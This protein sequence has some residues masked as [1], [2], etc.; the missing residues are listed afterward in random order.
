MSISKLTVTGKD[1]YLP[2]TPPQYDLFHNPKYK[3]RF[4][5]VP[6][7]RRFGITSSGAAFVIENLLMGKYVLWVDTIQGNIDKY[8]YKYFMPILKQI[9]LEYWRYKIASK[10]LRIINGNCDFR[11]LEQEQRIEGFGYHLIIV[12]EAGIVLKGSKG[13]NL[14]FNTLYPMILDYGMMSKVYFLGTPKGKKARKEE[15]KEFPDV[16]YSLYYE[17]ACKGGM[18]N[19][20][21]IEKH[22]NYRTKKYTSYDN[23]LLR[24]EDIDELK[25]DVPRYARKQEIEAEFLDINDEAI[26]KRSWFK[27]VH[28]LP[29]VHL[30]LRKI[31]SLDTAFKIG[32]ANDDSAGV[33][34]LETTL[35][36]FF[37][38]CFSKKLEFPDLIKKS[39]EFYDKNNASI[40]VIEDK[41]SGTPLAQSFKSNVNNHDLKYSISV[42][43]VIPV[44]D[45]FN[46][47]V[48]VSPMFEGGNVFVLFGAW[49]DMFIDQLCDFSALLDTPDDI[50]DATSQGLD[51]FKYNKPQRERIIS[52]PRKT[53]FLEGY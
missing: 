35:G 1:L 23:P 10:E 20:T 49:N 52:A 2:Y 14:W 19:N 38:D 34:I 9:K 45:K 44:I 7:G 48:A 24:K 16:K 5:V 30:W 12:N 13:R 50:V 21:Y 33:S 47:A 18:K 28:E 27:I 31:I 8:F 29:P 3:E 53:H 26:F 11:S 51:Y 39:I 15:K 32:N 40:M 4:I 36:Y 22:P 46:R 41:A 43:T 6:K 37:T 17:L 42:K 25:E